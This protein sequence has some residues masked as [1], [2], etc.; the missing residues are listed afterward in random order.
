MVT[1]NTTDDL[2]RLL[3]ENPEFREAVR[4]VILTQELTSLPAVFGSF[5]AEMR[6][7]QSETKDFQSEMRDFQSEMREFQSET[8]DFQSE[9]RGF[10][11]EMRGFQSEMRGFQSEMRD[12]QSEMREFQSETKDFQSEMC[13]FQSEM[14]AELKTHT[15]DIGVLKG[16][17]LES[18]LYNRGSAYIATLMNVYDI[19]RIRVAERDENSAEFNGQ[20]RDALESGSITMDDYNRVLRTDMIMTAR[21]PG[22]TAP[23]YIVVEASYTVHRS[24]IRKVMQT[25]SVLD[26]VFPDAESS[27]AIFYTNIQPFIM[28]EAAESGVHLIEMDPLE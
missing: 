17:G 22:A 1:I 8:K 6:D 21:A 19:T 9:M 28:D 16:L 18:K 10:Q 15:N 23:I 12:F 13:D 25:K 5:A 27:T 7:F 11:S 24:D 14:R 26:K 3:E 4:Q 2:L 20:L